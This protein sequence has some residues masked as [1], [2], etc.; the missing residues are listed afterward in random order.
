MKLGLLSQWYDPELGGGV[1]PGVLAHGLA[2]RG[3][4][5][6]VLTGFPNYPAG[7]I[8]P[9]FRQAWNHEESPGR[10]LTVR[11]SPLYPSHDANPAARAANYVSFGTTALIHA[12]S[13]FEDR[14]ALWVYNSPATVGAVARQVARRRGVPYLLHVMDLWPDSVLDSGM[15]ADGIPRRVAGSI[16]DGIVGRTH[17]AASLVAVTSPGQVD[18]LR[19]RGV[20]ADKLRYIP[21]WANEEIFRPRLPDRRWL[22]AGARIAG[23]VVMYAGAMGRVQHLEAVVRA[24][25]GSQEDVHLVMVGTGTEESSLRTLAEDLHAPNIHFMGA[26]PPER[27]GDISAAADLHVVSLADTPLL[28]ITMPSKIQSILALGRPII[29]A[30]TGDAAAVVASAGAGMSVPPGDE[31]GL[32]GAIEDA[33]RSPRQ[34]ESWGQAGRRYYE[35]EFAREVA[36]NRVEDALSQIS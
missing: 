10:G 24:I 22:P 18:V 15:L 9:G 19:K 5:V 29:A 2:G 3:H 25:A 28:R 27:M 26:Q 13:F 14:Q 1:V 16:L 32:R 36:V 8:Y 35:A 20:P 7:R 30:C 23:T 11:R 4:D 21:V 6:K 12:L 31:A 17:D 34:L 33:A